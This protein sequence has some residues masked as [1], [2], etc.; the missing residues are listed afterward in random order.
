MAFCS[1]TA[2]P[3]QRIFW[4]GTNTCSAAVEMGGSWPNNNQEQYVFAEITA[5]PLRLCY[6]KPCVQINRIS[7]YLTKMMEQ[8]GNYSC[9][10]YC[11]RDLIKLSLSWFQLCFSLTSSSSAVTDFAATG[12]NSSIYTLVDRKT[13]IQGHRHFHNPNPNLRRVFQ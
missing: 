8:A 10:M 11:R 6:F 13:K 12:M 3:H 1:P 5:L 7:N 9:L 4:H 2:A